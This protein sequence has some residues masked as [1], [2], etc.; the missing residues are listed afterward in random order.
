MNNSEPLSL[1]KNDDV[2]L[3][4]NTAS[5]SQERKNPQLFA[6]ENFFYWLLLT[7]LGVTEYFPKIILVIFKSLLSN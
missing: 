1:A 2:T 5:I 7:D 4:N 3:L 6:S